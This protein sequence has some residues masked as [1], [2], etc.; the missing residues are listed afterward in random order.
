M[1]V[2]ETTAQFR[3]Q[4]SDMFGAIERHDADRLQTHFAHD[5]ETRRTA[6]RLVVANVRGDH[7]GVSPLEHAAELGSLSCLRVLLESGGAKPGRCGAALRR[8]VLFGQTDSARLLT[9]HLDACADNG[10]IKSHSR[11]RMLVRALTTAAKDPAPTRAARACARNL[12]AWPSVQAAVRNQ[13]VLRPNLMRNLGVLCGESAS[14]DPTAATL[15]ANPRDPRAGYGPGHEH[16]IVGVR[17]D[18]APISGHVA[19]IAG[20]AD[21]RWAR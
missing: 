11:D 10:S 19:P 1:M 17:S 14:T 13:L 5:G 3:E 12:F 2:R 15:Q 18:R 6:L 8:A 16:E 4:L 21:S 20:E 7:D 9:R